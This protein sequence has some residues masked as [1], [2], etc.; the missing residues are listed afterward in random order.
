MITLDGSEM[1]NEDEITVFGVI[2][3][4]KLTFVKHVRTVELL[5]HKKLYRHIHKSMYII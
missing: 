1:V 4:T 3:D 2:I 5:C